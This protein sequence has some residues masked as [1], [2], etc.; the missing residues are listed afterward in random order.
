MDLNSRPLAERI[1]SLTFYPLSYRA[2][3]SF[4]QIKCFKTE[5]LASVYDFVVNIVMTINIS[6]DISIDKTFSTHDSVKN[7]FMPM[8]LTKQI[9][10]LLMF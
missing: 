2:T 3:Q 8:F 1:D 6:I 9:S 10:I 7:L 5:T 4:G